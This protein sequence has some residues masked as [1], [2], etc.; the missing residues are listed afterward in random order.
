MC[1][2]AKWQQDCHWQYQGSGDEEKAKR[3]A[4]SSSST[5][6]GSTRSA[7]DSASGGLRLGGVTA[8]TSLIVIP[9]QYY[10]IARP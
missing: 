5:V 3:F 2:F 4:G 7:E 9:T 6:R 8:G 1:Q 10:A